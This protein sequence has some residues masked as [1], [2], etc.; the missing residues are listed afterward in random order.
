MSRSVVLGGG[1]PVGIAWQTGL[2]V[3]L[4]AQGIALSNADLVV[5]TSAGSVVGLVLA[6]GGDLTGVLEMLGEESLRESSGT[7][8]ESSETAAAIDQALLKAAGSA[9][10]AD[11]ASDPNGANRAR[12]DLG[13]AALSASRIPEERWLARFDVF[14]GM[15][16]P[17]EFRCCTVDAQ[18]GSFRVWGPQDG[19]P[20]QLAVAASCAVPLLYPPVRLAGR[21]WIDGGVRDM[22]NADVAAGSDVAAV[23]SCTLLELPWQLPVPF[24][25][26]LLAATRRRVDVLR[27]D[28]RSVVTVV[29]GAEMLEVSEWGLALMDFTRTRAAYQA[30]ISQAKVEADRLGEDWR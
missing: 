26:A 1:G 16:W 7:A 15:E 5:G 23:V 29:P 25:D 3:G 30:G 6:S 13:R 19:V 24:L 2:I 11:L 18:D 14:A 27:A 22:L 9:A 17:S 8:A 28:A 10:T 4:A 21:H 12:A 20:P